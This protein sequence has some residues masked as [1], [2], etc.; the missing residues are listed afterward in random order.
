MLTTRR[1]A[2]P[3]LLAWALLASWAIATAAPSWADPDVPEGCW[4]EERAGDDGII[5]VVVVCPPGVGNNPGGG[6]GDSGGGGGG[7]ETRECTYR[8]LTI[9]CETRAGV[10]NGTCYAKVADPQPAADHPI[11]GGRTDGVIVQCTGYDAG[12]QLDCDADGGCPAGVNLSWAAAAPD[13]TADPAAVA[14]QALASMQLTA[15]TIGT[16]GGDMSQPDTMQLIGLPTWLWV[17]NPA[18]NTVG[19]ISATA[20]DGGVSVTVTAMLDRIEYDMGDGGTVVCAGA[21]AAG[22][23]YDESY[24]G[25]PSPT[26]GYE[27]PSISNDQ[28]GNAYTITATS[29]WTADWTGGGQTGSIPV[30]LDETT[31]LRVGEVQVIEVNPDS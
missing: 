23:P 14:R 22:T 28:P 19:P 3:V 8:G 20:S 6:G 12:D 1:L 4:T 21:A 5:T 11:W 26:C 24:G 29:Y 18:P 7:S 30:E 2:W 9:E 15:G 16:T 10:W 25:G 27:Y 17:E 31:T 13:A